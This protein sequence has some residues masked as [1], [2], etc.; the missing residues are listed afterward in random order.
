MNDGE[1]GVSMLIG[2]LKKNKSF[3]IIAAALIL[4]ILL[5]LFGGSG[6]TSFA[7]NNTAS[8]EKRVEELCARISGV[9]DVHVMITVDTDKDTVRGVALVCTGGE[10]PDVK[11]KLTNLL[12]ALFE[13]PSSAISVVGGK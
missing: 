10:L 5:M 13:I 1:V 6:G 4:G 11:L 2:F 12:C 3:G 9:S 8:L 7:G